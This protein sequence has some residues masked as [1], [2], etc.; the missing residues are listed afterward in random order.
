MICS[1]IDVFSKHFLL[2][3]SKEKIPKAKEKNHSYNK[4]QRETAGMH[5]PEEIGTLA[6]QNCIVMFVLYVI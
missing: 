2:N 1:S 3:P 6:H 5:W 4:K